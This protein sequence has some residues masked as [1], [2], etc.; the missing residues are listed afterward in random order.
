MDR[1]S[2]EKLLKQGAFET[3]SSA[4]AVRPNTKNLMDLH[5]VTNDRYAWSD[6]GNGNLFADWYKDTARYVPERK[7]WYIYNG[8][9]WEPDSGNL[10]AMEL[11]K[12]LAD[13]LAVYAL[14]IQ[15]EK[16]RIAYLCG[17]NTGCGS[18]GPLPY[19]SIET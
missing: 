7:R 17:S 3:S 13:D 6:I 19:P 18:M 16:Q 4:V 2:F 14:S 9:V 15:D 8:R 12:D 11:C 10:K 5:P 1:Q